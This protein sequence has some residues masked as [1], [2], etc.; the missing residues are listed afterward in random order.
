M[1]MY[2]AYWKRGWWVWLMTLCINLAIA[3]T[4][5]PLAALFRGNKSAYWISVLIVWFVVLAPF[6]GWVFERFA[7]GSQRIGTAENKGTT[8]AA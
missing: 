3:V 4:A 2:L 7:E 8:P 5:L 1:D 6:A